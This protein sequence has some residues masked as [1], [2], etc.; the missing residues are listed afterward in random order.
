VCVDAWASAGSGG[1]FRTVAPA[2]ESGIGLLLRGERVGS[3]NVP[4]NAYAQDGQ[5]LGE[6]A[7]ACRAGSLVGARFRPLPAPPARLSAPFACHIPYFPLP[8]SIWVGK[9]PYT[10]LL[11]LNRSEIINRKRK[12]VA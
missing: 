12:L 1:S 5:E 4:N 6:A 7:G 8:S 9:S 2:A 11:Y 3:E 10:I